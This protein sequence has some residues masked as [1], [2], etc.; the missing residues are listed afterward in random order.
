MILFDSNTTWIEADFFVMLDFKPGGIRYNVVSEM[1]K[2]PKQM[3][4]GALVCIQKK[5]Q[6]DHSRGDV[7]SRSVFYPR[8]AFDSQMTPD[9]DTLAPP[10]TVSE[11]GG[12]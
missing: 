6:G 5:G 1:Q 12:S 2:R 8:E 3:A 11:D 7:L 10:N 4:R 9:P